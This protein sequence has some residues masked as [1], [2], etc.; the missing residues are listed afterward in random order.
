MTLPGGER[1]ARRRERF[2]LFWGLLFRGLRASVTRV[3]SFYAAVGIFITAGALLAVAGTWAFA[4]LAIHVRSGATQAFDDAIL[5]WVGA[6][7]LPWVRIAMMQVTELGTGVV[8]M[9]VVAIAALFLWLTKHKHSASLLL[10]T[11]AVG[12][13]INSMLKD[14]F[15]RTRPSIFPSAVEVFSSSFPS[16][17]SM[18]AAIVYGTVAYLAGRLQERH[19]SRIITSVVAL[20]LILLIASS[21][22]YLGVHYP[23]DTLAGMVIGLAWAAFCMATLEAIQL[24]ARRRAPEALE[25]ERP[26]PAP[27]EREPETHRAP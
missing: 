7:Q 15:H 5:R 21:R 11:T 12:I 2:E 23:S 25:D 9:M 10:V 19:R 8:V 26:V 27:P 18:S 24:V 14:V 13:L 16:G 22:I 17:H 4:A 3:R 6:H 20:L 1:R